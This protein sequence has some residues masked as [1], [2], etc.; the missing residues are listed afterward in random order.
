METFLFENYKRNFKYLNNSNSIQL[1]NGYAFVSKPRSPMLKEFTL[2]FTGLRYY[3]NENDEVDYETNAYKD[4]VATLCDF[5]QRHGT[6][7]TFT[8]IDEQFGPL[9]VRFLE[10]LE[11]PQT[12]GRRGVV[13]EF[14]VTLQEVSE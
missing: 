1:G 12:D 10:P 5:Y 9:P 8:Y 6:Y 3:F 2:T 11:I 13:K 14:S 7:E 4:N